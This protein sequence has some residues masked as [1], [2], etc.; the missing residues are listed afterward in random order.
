MLPPGHIAAGFLITKGLLVLTKPALSA[1]EQQR[2]LWWGMFFG[3]APDLD[4]FAVFI[5]V[6]RFIGSDDISHR[7]FWSHAPILWL[8]GGLA[9]FF[10]GLARHNL[11]IEYFGLVAWLGSWSHFALDTVQHGVIWFWPWRKEPLALFDQGVKS[12]IPPQDFWPY[13][14]Q[15][16]KFYATR[17]TLSFCIELVAVI[18]ALFVYFR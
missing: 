16:V 8:I 15:S 4:T 7:K 11:F 9:I 1:I 6:K 13:W 18:A 5:K 3:F 14:F 2:L 17:F 10:F 12:H